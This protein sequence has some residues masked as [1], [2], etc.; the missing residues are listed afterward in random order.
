MEVLLNKLVSFAMPLFSPSGILG[1]RLVRICEFLVNAAWFIR[2]VVLELQTLHDELYTPD[3][4]RREGVDLSVGRVLLLF[5]SCRTWYSRA[6]A[7]Y[8]AHVA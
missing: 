5:G 4:L 3:G 1:N 2:K 6:R 7:D 8:D